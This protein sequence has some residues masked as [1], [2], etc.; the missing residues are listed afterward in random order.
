[1]LLILFF[2][3]DTN[4]LPL[5]LITKKLFDQTTQITS[6]Q[7]KHNQATCNTMLDSSSQKKPMLL[8]PSVS[9]AYTHKQKRITI[10]RE[11]PNICGLIYLPCRGQYT[12]LYNYYSDCNM[13]VA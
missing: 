2:D 7:Y 8:F 1:M 11:Q 5:L 12:F 10:H 4:Y 6:S 9:D 3:F 13:T